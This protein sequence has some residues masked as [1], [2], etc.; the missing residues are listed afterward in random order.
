MAVCDGSQDEAVSL[1][2]RPVYIAALSRETSLRGPEAIR[3]DDGTQPPP[4]NTE[5]LLG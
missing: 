5:I 4:C 1:F 3:R 2:C